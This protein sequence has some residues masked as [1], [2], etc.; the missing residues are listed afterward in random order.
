MLALKYRTKAQKISQF[1][2]LHIFVVSLRC[3]YTCQYCQVS[4]QTDDKT[5]FD[6]SEETANRSLDF[7]FKS[8]SPAIKIEFQGGEPLLNFEIIKHVVLAATER[9]KQPPARAGGLVS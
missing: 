7:V 5:A 3:D 4:R 8:P 2:A 6:M 1:T 9:T